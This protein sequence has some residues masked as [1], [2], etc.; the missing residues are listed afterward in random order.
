MNKPVFSLEACYGFAWK[1]FRK[2]WIPI[3]LISTFVMV[4]EVGPRILLRP[5]AAAFKA[6]VS[7][8][9]SVL[10]SGTLQEQAAMLENI[11]AACRTYVIQL[12]KIT[13][14]ALPF[15]AVL[16]IVLLMW[17]NIAVR[18]RRGGNPFGRLCYI[19]LLHIGL[20][21][22]KAAAF[23]FFI[24]PGVFLYIRLLFVDLILL[25]D[26]EQGV[27]NAVKK[28]WIMTEENFW[29]LLAMISINSV[30][31]L[32]A[33]LTIIGLIPVTGFSNTTRAAAYQML[34]KSIPPEIPAG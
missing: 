22:I 26:K 11:Q 7:K 24:F 25:E 4:F 9:L 14:L 20:V 16:S 19:A 32:L 21:F 12:C 15:V 30:F 29:S 31:Q 18:D 5:E 6:T 17:A 27:V 28:S 13:L 2:W 8:N 3:C 34:K 33:A 10:T 1:S 23:L